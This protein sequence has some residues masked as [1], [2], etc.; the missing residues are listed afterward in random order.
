MAK[1][2]ILP[3]EVV[4]KI[5]AG[6][7]VER[8]ASVV[9]ELME[10]SIDAGASKIELCL[11]DAGKTFIQIT[12][13][14]SGIEQDDLKNIFL[15]HSTSKIKTSNDLFDINSLGFR[16]EALYSISAISD[17]ILETKTKN[18]KTAWEMH[19]RGQERLNVKPSAKET[20]GTTFTIQE[21]FYNTPARRKFLKTNATEFNN[22]LNIFIPYTIL[23]NNIQFC[24]T[25]QNKS[26]FDL[27]PCEKKIDRICNVLGFNKKNILTE[28]FAINDNKAKVK[29]ILGD[30][31]IARTKKDMQFIF[32]NGRPVF[33]KTISFHLN[34]AYKLILQDGYSGFFAVYIDMP[35]QNIDVNIHPTKR[36]VKI[37]EES[38]IGS[39]IRH[40][41]E[42]LLMKMSAPK[43]VFE[44]NNN[45]SFPNGSNNYTNRTNVND[46]TSN[47]YKS[48]KIGTQKD[49][50]FNDFTATSHNSTSSFPN[51]EYY[52]LAGA[53][54]FE[55]KQ[56]SLSEKL[57]SAKYI[58]QFINK[59]LLFESNT[60]LLLID[61]HAAQERIVYE[62]L[63]TQ[64]ECGKVEVQHLLSPITIKLSPQEMHLI[65]ETQ[66]ILK[67]F[68]FETNLWDNNE[69]AISSYPSLIKDVEMSVRNLINEKDT[70]K[71]DLDTL[72]RRACRLSVMAGDKMT[73]IE[74]ISQKENLLKC[75]DP[76]TCPHGRPT[77][78]EILDDT[79]ERQFLRK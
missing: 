27:K 30:I 38:A 35:N 53:N 44:F 16:G 42:E 1:V 47:N 19:I 33:N 61:Q 11:K 18:D 25:H 79:L 51:K 7:V 2:H 5:A 41:A 77:V 63:L 55:Q 12:D 28:S 34:A 24:L 29:M 22:I 66:E 14:G 70:L 65:E 49:F 17:I 8:P 62:K 54:L 20:N 4:S 9:K 10:N 37:S 78:I 40:C 13:N 60:S 21:L 52:S 23:H 39:A 68:G 56:A 43:Q 59:Y 57:T 46:Y 69:F 76:F 32:I 74:A 48:D 26:L 72:A 58:G 75:L 64:V 45:V 73:A 3:N 31:N 71:C 50:S 6:E 15:R 67:Q 36:E